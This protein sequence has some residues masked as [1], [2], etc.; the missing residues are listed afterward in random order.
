MWEDYTMRGTRFSICALLAGVAT[1]TLMATPVAAQ[2]TDDEVALDDDQGAIDNV[3]VVTARRRAERITD[4]PL[5]VTALSGEELEKR[6]TQD[7][8]QIAPRSAPSC[9]ASASR[10]RSPAS[11]RV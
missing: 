5:A 3:I 1:A 10:I 9:A 4:V 6:G 11:R 8:T 2:Q 7:L